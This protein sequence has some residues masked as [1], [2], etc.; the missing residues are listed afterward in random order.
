MITNI[1]KDL[2]E[3]WA[4]KPFLRKTVVIALPIALQA[5][6]NTMLN[7]VD[8]IMIGK[9]SEST[10]SAV[11]AANKV[12]FVFTLL[13]FGV[14]SG[15]GIL[16]AQYW[17]KRDVKSIHRVLGM[18]LLL[19]LAASLLFLIPALLIP[20]GIMGILTD[21]KEVIGIGASYLAIVAI[22]Y[23]LTAVTNAYISVLRGVNQVKA[24]VVITVIAIL[25]NIVLDYILIFGKFGAPRMGVEGAAIATLIARVVECVCLVLLVYIRKSPAAGKIKNMLAFNRVFV[26]KF[27]ITVSPVI[28]NEFMWGLG[29]TLYAPVYGRMGSTA[30]TAITVTQT[31][32]Q[33]FMV[34]FQGLGA[35]TSVI[36]GNELGANHL[37]KAS[38]Y[39]K[40]FMILQFMAGIGVMIFCFAVKGPITVLF[41]LS[42]EAAGYV[43][44]CLTVFALYAP[45][46][47][48]NYI[49]IVG[50]L[51]SGGDTKAALFMDTTGVWLIGIP[52]VL[53]GGMVIH[54]PIYIVYAMV[55]SEE[56]YKMA[57]GI[58]RYRKKKWLRNIVG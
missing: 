50:V 26:K 29:V 33:I 7:L 36:L 17:G 34:I 9:L 27:F 40:N 47:M 21:S 35:A 28:A 2:R 5:F 15:A 43:R 14:M 38:Q 1:K 3:L 24:P 56:I 48:F 42:D 6:L 16:T 10:I 12:F 4:D 49:N 20:Q 31:L 45:F 46:K 54:A 19:G 37:K 18:S 53:L 23:P 13:L 41:S 51:R 52:M 55:M 8:T 25:V 57:V 30:F 39:A 32:E 11:G 58:P 22:S 44:L